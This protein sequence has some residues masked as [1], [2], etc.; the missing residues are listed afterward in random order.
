MAE[1]LKGKPVADR[2]NI[3]TR[4]KAEELAM[5]GNRPVLAVIRLGENPGDIAYEKG[6]VKRAA[7]TGVEITQRVFAADISQENLLEEIERINND[8]KIH[9]VLIFRPLPKHID[10]GAV[11]RALKPAKD[12]DGIT[13]GSMAGIFM[14]SGEGYPPCTA[15]ACIELMEHYGIE[16]SGK[17]VTVFGRSLVIGKP[18]AMMAMK[19][20]ATITICHSKTSNADFASSGAGADILI[21]AIGRANYVDADMTGDGQVII[22][23]GIN[24][25][26]NG[27]L[28]GD[29]DFASVESKAAAI[30]PVPGG[31]GSVT[32]AILM[33]HTV[34]AAEKASIE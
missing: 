21:A 3:I 27:N 20:N 2:L 19:K 8:D 14:D 5:T 16:M 23:V 9:G 29:V 24:T 4:K 25:D 26:E 34:E 6:I 1:L 32:T 13:A 31:V 10:D 15:E 11:C 28:C 18:V 17:K 33:K 7:E 22:D 12:M 30:T